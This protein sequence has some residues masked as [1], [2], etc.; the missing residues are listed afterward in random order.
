MDFATGKGNLTAAGREARRVVAPRRAAF[1]LGCSDVAWAVG[2]CRARV[3]PRQRV[4]CRRG[5]R[6]G[7][8]REPDCGAA[9]VFG[10]RTGRCHGDPDAADADA[11]ER[12]DLEQLETDGAAGGVR[13]VGVVEADAA[14]GAQQDIGH[15]V[16]PQA[17]LVGAHRGGRGAIRIEVELALLDPVL[18]VAAGAVDLLVEVL[19]LA[20][21]APERSDHEARIGFPLRPLGLGDDP[22]PAAPAP[23]R[24]PHEALEAALRPAGAPA[25]GGDDDQARS[26][27]RRPAARSAPVRTGSRRRWPRTRPSGPPARSLSRR[28]TECASAAS[29]RG[30]A[31][32]RAPPPRPRRPPRPC[33]RSAA[34]RPADGGRR[35]HRAADSSSSRSSRGRTAPPARRAV[36]HPSHRGRE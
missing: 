28:A 17:Q 1:I 25:L 4:S 13:E 3:A 12:P 9:P 30:C 27:S 31:R 29:G 5:A 34:W 15:R 18:H 22:A 10:G 20:L 36:D 23:A 8:D 11:H 26:R 6:D 19:G 16:E 7:G 21:V 35:T 2:L 33:R 32:P 24:R 14:Q